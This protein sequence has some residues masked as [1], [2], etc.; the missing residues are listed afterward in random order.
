MSTNQS[1]L[2]MH[3]YRRATGRIVPEVHRRGEPSGVLDERQ[4]FRDVR[5]VGVQVDI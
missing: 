3:P 4:R 2:R 5:A 1:R